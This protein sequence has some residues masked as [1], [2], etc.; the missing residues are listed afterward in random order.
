MANLR[1]RELYREG[2]SGMAQR[3]VVARDNRSISTGSTRLAYPFGNISG[4]VGT[5]AMCHRLM[6]TTL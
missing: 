1:T 5:M 4:R 6:R 2:V 3:G